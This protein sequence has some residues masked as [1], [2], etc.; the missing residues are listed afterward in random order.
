MRGGRGV[1]NMR[2][3]CYKQLSL[4]M[5]VEGVNGE[6]RWCSFICNFRLSKF[7]I[8]VVYIATKGLVGELTDT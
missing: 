6:A 5:M 7:L 1:L 2:Y 8:Y 3:L 4:A